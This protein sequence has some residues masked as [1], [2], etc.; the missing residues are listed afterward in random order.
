M[1]VLIYGTFDFFHRGHINLL[2]RALK[3]GDELYIGVSSDEFNLEKGKRSFQSLE[4]RKIKIS[5][6]PGVKKVFTQNS[7]EQKR[8]DILKYD[9][10]VIVSGDDWRGSIDGLKDV[11]RVVYLER[12]SGISSTLIRNKVYK[13][14]LSFDEIH[15]ISYEIL[16]L[17]KKVCE[18]HGITYWL[19]AGSLLGAVR[20]NNIIPWDDDIDVAMP[21]EDFEKFKEVIPQELPDFYH[22]KHIKYYDDKRFNNCPPLKI[23]DIRYEAMGESS[24]GKNIFLDIAPYDMFSQNFILRFIQKI[25]KYLKTIKIGSYIRIT[26]SHSLK[27]KILLILCKLIYINDRFLIKLLEG[28]KSLHNRRSDVIYSHSNEVSFEGEIHIKDLYPLKEIRFRTHNFKVPQ[29]PHNYLRKKYGDYLKIPKDEDLYR[30]LKDIYLVDH[31][32]EKKIDNSN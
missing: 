25:P 29:N 5:K 24:D 8:E 23:M 32:R 19:S 1:R 6:F 18:K 11:C 10:D 12:T 30:H 9:I 2:K 14:K 26:S 22:L 31:I 4:T 20:H 15:D 3:F 16:L 17:I 7:F 28:F 13:N 21:R 27:K